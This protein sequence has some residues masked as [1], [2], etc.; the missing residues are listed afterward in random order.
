MKQVLQSYRTGEL[1]LAEVPMAACGPGGVLVRTSSSLVSAGTE[2]MLMTLAKKSLLGKAAA[3]PDLVKQVLK[4][5]QTEGLAGTKEKVFAKLDEPIT[6]GYSAAGTVT[7]CGAGVGSL[8]P[9]DRV[10]IAGA[11]YATH[12]EF[13]FVPE[14][15]C[16]RIPEGVSDDD[17][18]FATV[19]AIAMQGIRQAEP[20]IGERFV[21]IGLG[22]LGLLTVQILKANGCAVLG[23]DPDE[24]KVRLARSLG[25]DVALASDIEGACAA[26]TGGRGADGVIITAATPSHGPIETAAEVSRH[27]GRVVA[28]GLVGMNVPRDAFYRK[29]LDLRLSMSYGPGRYD[30]AYEEQGND[31]PFAYVRFTEQRNLESFLYLVQQGK[32]TPAALV[33]HRIAFED[34]LD[35]YSLL[36]G[37]LSEESELAREYL[38]ILLQYPESASPTRTIVSDAKNAGGSGA[39][40]VGVGFVG[41]GGFAKAVLLPHLKRVGGVNLAGVCTSTG[42]SA[43][44]SADRFG[45]GLATT[46]AAQILEHDEIDAVFVATRHATH[47]SLT[48]A[49]LRA[50]KH[51]FVE[52][53]LCI[54]EA[55][56]EVIEAALA[57]ARSDGH[58]PCLMVG[59][60]RR[61]SPHAAAIR[62]AFES[63]STPLVVN[64]RVNAGAI[65][66][67]SWIHDP[68][69]GGG[70]IIGE[71]CHFVDFCSSIVAR[72]P[73]SVMASSISSERRDVVS[74][75]SVVITIKYADGS[76]ANIQYLAEGHR[77][78]AK[79]RCE[80]FAGGK[81]A[82]LDDYRETVFFGGGKKLRGKQEKGFTEEL[83][84]FLAVCREGGEWPIPWRSLVATHRVC[85]AALRSLRTDRRVDLLQPSS[86]QGG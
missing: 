51:V 69:D 77:D 81:T 42:K 62:A 65:P 43:Q 16:A 4:K 26:F 28:V 79:E 9:G 72:D 60:N 41:A 68:S 84:A 44:Q 45:F 71:V 30:P 48:A 57:D 40:Q 85:F 11:G 59:F 56:L 35:A 34:A 3:R 23:V 50:G 46:D 66:V 64:Y 80:V 14:N 49:A 76:L 29:E 58:E 75:D 18:A 53:P 86:D 2:K 31:Y 20:L 78:L 15:L 61:F 47:A 38:G 27:K 70:R 19:G 33:S 67:D 82:V 63:R 1:W 39:G 13:N 21:V 24:K 52:K 55:G 74:E 83:T 73:V 25:A 5:V 6:L 22:L 8:Q 12:A 32:V 37:T 54:D 10:A 36:E 17:A 7:E